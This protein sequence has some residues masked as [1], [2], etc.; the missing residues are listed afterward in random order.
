MKMALKCCQFLGGVLV[1][2]TIG[3]GEASAIDMG[4]M[5]VQLMVAFALM[6]LGHWGLKAVSAVAIR[7][8]KSKGIANLQLRRVA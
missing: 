2:G 3:A 7:K 8:R 5:V 4:Q 6:S 1:F